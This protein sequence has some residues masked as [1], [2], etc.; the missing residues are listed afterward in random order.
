MFSSSFYKN[1]LFFVFIIASANCA[2]SNSTVIE[3]VNKLCFDGK[4][5][6][7]LGAKEFNILCGC[8]NDLPSK[9][10]INAYINEFN[11]ANRIISRSLVFCL[12]T[13]EQTKELF[14]AA[15][16]SSKGARDYFINETVNKIDWHGIIEIDWDINYKEKLLEGKSIFQNQLNAAVEE[17]Y[18]DLNLTEVLNQFSVRSDSKNIT[19][20]VIVREV[21]LLEAII[22]TM[23]LREDIE[24]PVYYKVAFTLYELHKH[25]EITFHDKLI[26][27]YI[28][29]VVNHIAECLKVTIFSD[30]QYIR[31]VNQYYVKMVSNSVF[32]KEFDAYYD[33]IR[34][35][36]MNQ[37]Y[38]QI[39]DVKER[40]NFIPSQ[41]DPTSCYIQP[42]IF[43]D[44]FLYIDEYQNLRKNKLTLWNEHFTWKIFPYDRW[45]N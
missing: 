31:M 19:I 28:K 21:C 14:R 13:D 27:N 29:S 18:N 38:K 24:N 2:V 42:V 11:F 26:R 23:H 7:K 45:R 3:Y 39:T 10:S 6:D 16:S 44:Y 5:V 33:G 40:F 35:H 9:L 25:N 15:V 36:Q 22:K 41:T 8:F 37:N 34:I 4:H 43:P 32:E 12:R 30:M 1:V 17:F 20:S